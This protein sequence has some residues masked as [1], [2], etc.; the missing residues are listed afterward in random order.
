MK[1]IRPAVKSTEQNEDW[2]VP[3]RLTISNAI[4]DDA[5]KILTMGQN[6]D[7]IT[8]EGLECVYLNCIPHKRYSNNY[9]EIIVGDIKCV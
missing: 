8:F 6:I 9:V 3:G 5:Q 2:Q 7:I 4:V 1:L